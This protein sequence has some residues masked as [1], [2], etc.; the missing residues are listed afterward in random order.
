MPLK[1][2]NKIGKLGEDLICKYL[3]DKGFLIEERNYLKKWGE[4][5]VISSKSGK[6]HFIEVKSVSCKNLDL[7]YTEYNPLEK[8]DERKQRRLSRVIESYLLEHEILD[9]DNEW[10]VDIATVFIDPIEHA[11][12]I[13]ILRDVVL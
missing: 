10:Q 1:I 11:V 3:E 2:T 8:V 5:D 6:T 4:I 7:S 13:K 12:K 9:D